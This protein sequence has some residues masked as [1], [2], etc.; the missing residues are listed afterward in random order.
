[1]SVPWIYLAAT[2]AAIIVAIG[3]VSAVIVRL[4]RRSPLNVLAE[5]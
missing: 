1:L 2:A 3:A 5:L 4:A